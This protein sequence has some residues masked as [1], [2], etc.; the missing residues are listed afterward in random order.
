MW[1]LVSVID[2][3][4]D[5]ATEESPVFAH[6]Y[7]EIEVEENV[8]VPL[9]IL[10]L[11]VTDAYKMQKLR[12]SLV[13]EKNSDIK[14]MFRIDPK[15]GTLYVIQSPDREKKAHYELVVRLD[16][17]KLGRDMTVMVYPVTNERLGNLGWKFSL[18]LLW[19]FNTRLFVGLNEVKVIVRIT[20]VNDNPPKFMS[21]GR[22]IVA[23]IP[24][25]AGYGYEVIRLQVGSGLSSK[26]NQVSN[27]GLQASDPDLGIN[28]EVRFQILSRNEEANRRFAIDSV[29]GQIRATANFNKDVGKVFGFDVKATDKNGA[30]DG[31]STIANVLV[32]SVFFK[33]GPLTEKNIW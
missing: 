31:L 16:Q 6:R 7:Y 14:D 4:E 20:D 17:Y 23:A 11:N 33:A 24:A 32:S 15:N 8:P 12:F 22:P 19:T 5:I 2:V 25:T 10:T 21:T 26:D 27:F 9:K 30:D 1:V 3:P 29:S 13:N 18:S 28:G